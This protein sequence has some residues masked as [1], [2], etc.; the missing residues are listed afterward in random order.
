MQ[1]T[2]SSLDADLPRREAFE[3]IFLNLSKKPGLTRFAEQGFGWKP[4][5]G[6]DTFTL[7]HEHIISAQWSRAARGYEVKIVS[8]KDGVIQLDGFK[9]EVRHPVLSVA[10][11]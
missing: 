4:S 6:G 3:G 10:C 8:R 7:D 2:L 5:T 11:I 9:Q 1:T